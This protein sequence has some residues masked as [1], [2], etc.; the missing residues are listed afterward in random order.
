[1]KNFVTVTRRERQ[2]RETGNDV[3]DAVLAFS[4]ALRSC[5]VRNSVHL[6]PS[7]YCETLVISERPM[8]LRLEEV[9]GAINWPLRVVTGY[10][11]KE[12]EVFAPRAV[13][14][15]PYKYLVWFSAWDPKPDWMPEDTI[16]IKDDGAFTMEEHW[17]R[18]V[19]G[20]FKPVAG[21]VTDDAIG[22]AEKAELDAAAIAAQKPPAPAPQAE[23]VKETRDAFAVLM[24]SQNAGRGDS[25][26]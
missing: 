10:G 5:G 12:T 1:M 16:E 19:Y 25:D 4:M 3:A 9:V 23:K 8:H 17:Q 26:A 21:H 2:P 22:D 7:L 24:G 11:V 14:A 15:I 13:A 20:T 6:P 18:S